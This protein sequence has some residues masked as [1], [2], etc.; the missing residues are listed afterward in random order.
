MARQ[1]D[2]K[3]LIELMPPDEGSGESGNWA[4]AEAAWGM[5][6][7]SDYIEFIT[8]YGQGEID[9]SLSVAAPDELLPPDAPQPGMRG[10]TEE[11]RWLFEEDGEPTEEVR[12]ADQ[13][14][15]WGGSCTA[16]TLAWLTVGD[17]PDAWPVLV[18]DRNGGAPL[19]FDMGMVEF[20]HGVVSGEI[21]PGP[22]GAVVTWGE[23]P[24]RFVH[25][26]AE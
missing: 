4:A 8:R 5:R 25:W 18:L 12:S 6:F 26:R 13:I 9:R 3:R 7:P 2:I 22:V 11:A 20:L 24:P 17:D 16:D 19:L 21:S 14:I 23:R 1:F 10:M 15:A